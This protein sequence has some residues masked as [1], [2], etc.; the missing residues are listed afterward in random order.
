MMINCLAATTT[1]I[2]D[3]QSLH[4]LGKFLRRIY[5]LS[6]AFVDEIDSIKITT[7]VIKKAQISAF[8]LMEI[9]KK[10]AHVTVIN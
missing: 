7:A 2:L 3:E 6:I 4:Y 9:K 5:L 10:S 1:T 8:I